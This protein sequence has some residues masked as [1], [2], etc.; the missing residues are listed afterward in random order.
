MQSCDHQSITLLSMFDY[1]PLFADCVP[2]PES[3][4][5]NSETAVLAKEIRLLLSSAPVIP[6]RNDDS[7]DYQAQAEAAL[8][9]LDIKIGDKVV[10]GGVKVKPLFFALH[11][12][13]Q[14]IYLFLTVMMTRLTARL[15]QILLSKLVIS[16]LLELR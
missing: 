13:H 9:V 10:V 15:R 11:F 5:P 3:F 1:Y 6:E 8:K 2:P 7:I 4:E 12:L 16:K 14:S